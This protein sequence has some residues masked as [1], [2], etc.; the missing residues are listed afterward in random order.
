MSGWKKIWI[1]I[2][3]GF[4][5]DAPRRFDAFLEREL[6]GVMFPGSSSWTFQEYL[7][8]MLV[9]FLAFLPR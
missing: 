5:I 4:H 8:R 6:S 3:L 1:A 9:D 2:R 7:S